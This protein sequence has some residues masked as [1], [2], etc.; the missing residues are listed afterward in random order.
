MRLFCF[1]HFVFY[2]KQILQF[3]LFILFSPAAVNFNDIS[4]SGRPQLKL[5]FEC[6]VQSNLLAF[7]SVIFLNQEF[8]I[9]ILD[10]CK[11]VGVNTIRHLKHG[12]VIRDA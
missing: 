5:H 2:L 12:H 8:E 7:T 9:L 3:S 4:C 1:R 10:W 11:V 6:A